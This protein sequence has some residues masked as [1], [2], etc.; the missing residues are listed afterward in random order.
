[1]KKLPTYCYWSVA[2]GDYAKMLSVTVHSARSVGVFKD[3][4]VWTPSH[5]SG[6]TCHPCGTFDKWGCLFK[7]TFLRD[8]VSKLNY[9]YFIWL[10]TD[11]WFV[12][13]PGDPLRTL[14]GSPIHITLESD[15]A[16]PRNQ[17]KEWWDCPN[18][19]FVGLMRE[20]G[21]KNR[22]IFNVNGGMFIVHHDAVETVF[23]LAYDFWTFCKANDFTFNDE[24]LLAYAMQMLCGNPY[25]HT[26]RGTSD[27]WASDWAGH[28]AGALPQGQSWWFSD[29]FTFEKIPVNPAIVHL[30]RSKDALLAAAGTL[31][32]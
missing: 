14:N 5:V 22:S 16:N 7:L 17:R 23:D 27:F 8:A 26:L 9:D 11:T 19:T 12:R 1:M 3:F 29:Y 28:F 18:E 13:N 32:Q 4:H 25:A 20:K 10:D 30:L 6:A 24:P 2:D 21:V 15:L 31:D